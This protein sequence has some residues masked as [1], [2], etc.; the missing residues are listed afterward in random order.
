M[1]KRAIAGIA[2]I[3]IVAFLKILVS[4]KFLAIIGLMFLEDT[5]ALWLGST[6][7]FC[8]TS[9]LIVAGFALIIWFLTEKYFKK[10]RLKHLK[11]N[12]IAIGIGMVIG[13]I[14][15]LSIL[16]PLSTP[17]MSLTA[18]VTQPS[19]LT[20]AIDL[21]L[22]VWTIGLTLVILAMLGSFA[23]PDKKAFRLFTWIPGVVGGTGVILLIDSLPALI[24][25]I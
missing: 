25:G 7:G 13:I 19:Q 5:I 9:L 10:R 20:P 16:S 18:N 3:S 8:A 21:G 24:G 11:I 23:F 22:P 4:T 12:P 15:L 6:V 17:Q 1:A 2:L 14:L